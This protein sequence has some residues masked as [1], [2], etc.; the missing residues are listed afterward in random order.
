MQMIVGITISNSQGIWLGSSLRSTP[1]HLWVIWLYIVWVQKVC[2]RQ[3]SLAKQNVSRVSRGKALLARYSRDTAVSISIYTD[4]S[5]SSHVQGTCITSRD[6]KSRDTCKNLFSLQQLESSYS[7]F[8]TQ[9]LQ[10]N[11]TINTRYKRLI[12][13]T[14]KFGTELKP[15]KH[16]FVN[17][18][19]TKETKTK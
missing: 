2:I 15:T 7:L 17:H 8:I 14:I 3:H 5:H 10:S 13:I 16:I 4:S 9:P 6:A 1:L 19:F 18:N 11:P 12:K